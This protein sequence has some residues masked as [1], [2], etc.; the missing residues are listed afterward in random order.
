MDTKKLTTYPISERKNLVNTIRFCSKPKTGISLWDFYNSLPAMGASLDFHHL[1]DATV[2]AHK[3]G[4]PVIVMMGG[5]VIK[6]GCSPAIIALMEAGVITSVAM[7]G[8]A[9]IHDFEIAMIGA[10]SED[11]GTNVEDGKFGMW[12]ETGRLW[13]EAILRDILDIRNEGIGH[14]IG[15]YMTSNKERFPYID[16]SIIHSAYW[17]NIPVTVHVAIGTDIV[18]QHPDA[19]G[20]YIGEGTMADFHNFVDVVCKLETGSVVLNFGSAVIMPE[21]FLKAVAM[22]RNM[23]YKVGNFIAA[24]FDMIKHYRPVENILKR[25][26]CD[27]GAGYHIA[28]RHEIMIPLFAHCVLDRLE[29]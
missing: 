23:G 8:A 24:N 16:H 17:P 22:A 9:S 27:D 19:S 14:N 21:V 3:A 10:T 29:D 6:C 28:G 7:N 20:A 1:V 5:H 15:R 13:N 26:N 18:H 11:V 4:L 25:A 2:E 12:E